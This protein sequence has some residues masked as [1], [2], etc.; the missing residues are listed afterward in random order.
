MK[1]HLLQ[2]VAAALMCMSL[3][4]V[5][6]DSNL[7]L[8]ALIKKAEQGDIEAQKTLG[9]MY[10]EGNGVTHNALEAI[11]WYKMAANKGD[12]DAQFHLGYIYINGDEAIKNPQEAIKWYKMAAMQ[13]HEYAP[14]NLALIY[15]KGLGVKQSLKEALKWYQKAC[16]LGAEDACDK[17]Q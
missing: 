8:N 4:T 13:D 10:D 7:D 15:E 3:H 17:V 2:V 5:Y 16:D 6:A 1:K 9:F 14:F 12:A 11:K